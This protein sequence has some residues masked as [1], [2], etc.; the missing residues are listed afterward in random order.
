MGKIWACCRV[1]GHNVQDISLWGLISGDYA[2][3]YGTHYLYP[4]AWPIVRRYVDKED[5]L[6]DR[7]FPPVVHFPIC[8]YDGYEGPCDD[9][10]MDRIIGP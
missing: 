9:E 6:P 8:C 4:P 2:K 3:N 5:D 1:F 10:R 7:R